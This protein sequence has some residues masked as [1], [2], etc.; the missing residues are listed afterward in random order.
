MKLLVY[1]GKSLP[2]VT[3][4]ARQVPSKPQDKLLGGMAYFK[5][6]EG[7]LVAGQIK[8]RVEGGFVKVLLAVPDEH[9]VLVVT[10]SEAVVDLDA[11]CLVDAAHRK[12]D[13][14]RWE[15]N[16]TVANVKASEIKDGD[17]LVDYTG[18]KFDGL[19]STFQHITPE[20]RDGDY[21]ME[22]AFDSSL[23][24]FKENPVMLVDHNRSVPALAGSYSSVTVNKNGLALT[25]NV[26]DSPDMRHVRFLIKEGHLRTLSMG[27]FFFYADDFK[28]IKEV[29]L[30]EVS[31]VA[32]P[33]NPDAVFQSRSLTVEDVAEATKTH[34]KRHSGE[35]RQKIA[36]K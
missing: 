30:H 3:P 7:L 19:G 11:L 6:S 8:E 5:S 22:G 26:S 17:V 15:T 10:K 14:L 21:V 9:G 28:G 23:A 25:G 20:D 32:I 31:L 27:G 36:R 29:D 4:T 16:D 18:V 35:V 24:R 12:G 1:P 13:V 2:V 34:A 33:S